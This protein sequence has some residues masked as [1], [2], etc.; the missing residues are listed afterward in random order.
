M[1]CGPTAV[2]YDVH[3]TTLVLMLLFPASI[4]SLMT[5]N[6]TQDF[7]YVRDSIDSRLIS[8]SRLNQAKPDEAYHY[9]YPPT[10]ISI[11][12][13]LS[14]NFIII[15]IMKVTDTSWVMIVVVVVFMIMIR[16]WWWRCSNDKDDHDEC[17]DNEGGGGD[18]DDDDD[19]DHENNVQMQQHYSM[20]SLVSSHSLLSHNNCLRRSQ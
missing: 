1:S 9:F 7:L 10:G 8:E 4:Q 17:G 19:D 14:I 18:D 11:Y 16:L 2:I 15:I 13:S 20:L 6:S 3:Q 5:C 12:S